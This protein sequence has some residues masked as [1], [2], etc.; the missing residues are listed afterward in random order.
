MPRRLDVAGIDLICTSSGQPY[1]TSRFSVMSKQEVTECF[2]IYPIVY[3]VDNKGVYLCIYTNTTI[4]THK[5][6]ERGIWC[7]LTRFG[8]ALSRTTL[9][10]VTCKYHGQHI[11]DMLGCLSQTS[12]HFQIW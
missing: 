2:I 9:H 8:W 10:N 4:H 5:Q 12:C 3:Y 7:A 6:A 11:Y 1:L